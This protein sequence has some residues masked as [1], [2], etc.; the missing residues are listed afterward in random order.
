[1]KSGKVSEA[2]LKRS[3]LKTIKY[4]SEYMRASSEAGNDAAITQE[5]MVIS[6]C[7]AGLLFSEENLYF[8]CKRSLY[9]AV[10][11]VAAGGG[12]AKGVIVDIVMPEK[13]LESELRELMRYISVLCMDLKLHIAGGN[14]EVSRAVRSSIIS[15]TVFGDY[16]YDEYKDIKSCVKEGY[17]IIMTKEIGIS[18]TVAIA[19]EKYSELK[20]KFQVSYIKKALDL[21]NCMDIR[22]E[23]AIGWENDVRIMH[24]LS[25]GGIYAGLWQLAE[26]TGKGIE[27]MMD[28]IR[29]NQETIELCE[30]YGIN[31]YKMMSNG[32]L[33]MVCDN[34]EMLL[35]ELVSH[36]VEAEIIGRLTDNNDKV[37]LKNED[38]RY[39]EPPK[40]D[41]LEKDIDEKVHI[42]QF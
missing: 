6:S 29:I 17:N 23:A 27:V 5:G 9:S 2:I 13:R 20:E 3:V 28:K 25:R 42:R 30:P 31:P 34:G 7:V 39:I 40:R 16:V 4:K 11:N 24:D 38:R 12:I 21:E 37:I 32:A 36:G 1:M 26:I 19:K 14:T 8:D 41:E 15:F 22:K 10:N 18:G 35:N 33:L